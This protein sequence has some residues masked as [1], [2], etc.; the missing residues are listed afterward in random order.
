M[1]KLVEALEKIAEECTKNEVSISFIQYEV[2]QALQ[3]HA[4]NKEEERIDLIELQNAVKTIVG[5]ANNSH[6]IVG[7]HLNGDILTWG[8][9]ELFDTLSTFSEV[10]LS[11]L[12]TPPTDQ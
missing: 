6:G 5:I 3:E 9:I 4:A 8:E 12:P 2:Q 1:N 11:P 7:W 10:D